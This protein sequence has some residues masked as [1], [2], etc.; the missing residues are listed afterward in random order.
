MNR[1]EE[2]SHQ[3]VPRSDLKRRGALGSFEERRPNNNNNNNNNNNKMSSDVGSVPDP[4]S[5]IQSYS[6][7]SEKLTTEDF[8]FGIMEVSNIKESA[9]HN[10]TMLPTAKTAVIIACIKMTNRCTTNWSH[11]PK[12]LERFAPIITFLECRSINTP[13]NA[14]ID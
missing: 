5:A 6:Y 9:Y 11:I 4:K 12:R 10:A 14:G 1:V 3:I 2:Q 13:C 7:F 8:A